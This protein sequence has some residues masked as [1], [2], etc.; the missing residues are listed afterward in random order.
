MGLG[1]TAKKIQKVADIAEDLYAKV[2]ELKTQL[3]E[4]R[5][6][7]EETNDRV[8]DLDREL[9]EQRALLEAIAD[10]QGIDVETVQTEALIDDAETE[11]D[12]DDTTR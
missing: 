9:A 5:G 8:D 1:S 7:V 3:Q 4:L 6:T 11:P 12:T 10:E 2:T